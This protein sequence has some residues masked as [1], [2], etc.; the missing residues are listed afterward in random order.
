MRRKIKK[1]SIKLI[2]SWKR[3]KYQNSD[4]V[5]LPEKVAYFER[6]RVLTDCQKPIELEA[7]PYR[8]VWRLPANQ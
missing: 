4:F 3:E 2:V 1:H 7:C 5:A 6:I 8:L